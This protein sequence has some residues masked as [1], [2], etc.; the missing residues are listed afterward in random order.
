MKTKLFY[1]TL[2]FVLLCSCERN[3]ICE[4]DDIPLE[5]GGRTPTLVIVEF[6]KTEYADYIYGNQ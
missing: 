1:L 5:L 6:E 3:S 2:F 4:C